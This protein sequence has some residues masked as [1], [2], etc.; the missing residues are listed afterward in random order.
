MTIG[1]QKYFDA[2]NLVSK[3][4]MYVAIET[5][6]VCLGLAVSE[7]FAADAAELRGH[8]SQVTTLTTDLEELQAEVEA[9]CAGLKEENALLVTDNRQLVHLRQQEC[10]K[11]RASIADQDATIQTG[12]AENV[13][14]IARVQELSMQVADRDVAAKRLHERIADLTAELELANSR[15]HT[16]TVQASTP[17]PIAYTREPGGRVHGVYD[18]EPQANGSAD[19]IPY[20]ELVTV[21]APAADQVIDFSS[22]PADYISLFHRLLDGTLQWTDIAV[23]ARRSI[24]LCVISQLAVDGNLTMADF[25]A[26]KP[27]FMPTPDARSKMFGIR[28]SSVVKNAVSTG[29][30]VAA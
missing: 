17:A 30:A 8:A 9:E 18:G 24:A 19:A 11:L 23:P 7:Q 29:T 2:M 10:A 14:L 3:D 1:T 20:A 6:A 22:L 26:N 4:G 15:P 13:R 21:S 5:A 12:R 16:L 25:A 28:W 27:V